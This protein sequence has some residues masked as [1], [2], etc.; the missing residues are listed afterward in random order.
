MMKRLL[1]GLLISGTVSFMLGV[2]AAHAGDSQTPSKLVD[3]LVHDAV[4]HLSV[5]GLARTEREHVVRDLIARYSS[6]EIL[7]QHVLGRSWGSASED[8]RS[9]F[10]NR[11]GDYMVA[12][13]SGMLKDVPPDVKLVVN[14][15]EPH[16]D[17]VIVHSAFVETDGDK[18]NVD[19]SVA[20]AGDGHLFL[21]DVEA[22]GV[23]LVRTMSSDFRAVLFANGGHIAALLA[24]MNH[25]ISVAAAKPD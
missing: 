3:G 23:S 16:G 5:K 22:E 20:T 11:F 17:Q 4:A 12:L 21:N 13:C 18:T 8:E 15:E 2:P 14:G 7:A 25:K 6:Q 1:V 19:W 9:Q 10:S 24:E